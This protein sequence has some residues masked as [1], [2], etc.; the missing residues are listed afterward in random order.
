M[1]N[2]NMR[3]L[4]FLSAILGMFGT[5]C[6]SRHEGPKQ[7]NCVK[8]EVVNPESDSLGLAVVDGTVEFGDHNNNRA[9]DANESGFIKFKVTNQDSEPV[10]DCRAL[11]RISGIENVSASES[12]IDKIN[13]GETVEVTIHLTTPL[14]APD[15]TMTA[16]VMLQW[17]GKIRRAAVVQ[18]QVHAA[19]GPARGRGR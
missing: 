12:V 14:D 6:A 15:A 4:A 8:I 1:V 2:R 13:P 9:L 5:A 3:R 18:V 17:N 11:L 16:D 19:P 7:E 10:A